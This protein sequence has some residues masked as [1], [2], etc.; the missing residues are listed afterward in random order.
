MSGTGHCDPIGSVLRGGMILAALTT[1]VFLISNPQITVDFKCSV[2]PQTEEGAQKPDGT[3]PVLQTPIKFFSS[4]RKLSLVEDS[5][6]DKPGADITQSIVSDRFPSVP[7]MVPEMDDT[8]L[9]VFVQLGGKN[10]FGRSGRFFSDLLLSEVYCPEYKDGAETTVCNINFPSIQIYDQ[11]NPIPANSRIRVKL[12]RKS[13]ILVKDINSQ[14]IGA[15]ETKS[16]YLNKYSRDENDQPLSSTATGTL[17]GYFLYS[18]YQFEGASNST[19]VKGDGTFDVKYG[20]EQAGYRIPVLSRHNPKNSNSPKEA[21]LIEMEVIPSDSAAY[22]KWATVKVGSGEY[23]D[24]S[25]IE[26]KSK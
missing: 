22:T 12:F 15:E 7:F 14:L 18:S 1:S 2:A 9:S 6:L 25:K 3:G 5:A 13:N 24:S 26:F 10:T 20:L 21:Y 17:S 4:K 19:P 8:K 16:G 11:K 23:V